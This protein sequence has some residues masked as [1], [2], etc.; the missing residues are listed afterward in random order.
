MNARVYSSWGGWCVATCLSAVWFAPGIAALADEKITYEDH[1]KPLL[2]QRCASCHNPNNKSGDLD[3]T[4]YTALML[5]GGS[6]PVI[7]PLEPSGSYM[8]KLITHEESPEMPPDADR[9]PDPEI[10]VIRKW[11]EGGG[12]ENKSSKLVA[13]KKKKVAAVSGDAT[14]RPEV[15]PQPC[16]LSLDVTAVPMR[17]PAVM[18]MATSPW[19]PITAVGT[20]FQVLLFDSQTLELRGVLPFP[21]G[22]IHALRFSRNGQLL[23]AGGGR[24][25]ANGVAVAWDI[26]TGERVVEISGLIDA[27]LAADISSDHTRVAVGTTDRL[28]RIFDTGSGEMLHEIKKHTD[29]IQSLEFSP[30]GVLLAT[31]DRSGGLIVWEALT[32]REYLDLRGHQA[33]INAVSWRVDSNVLASA[34]SDASIRL[35]EMENGG[36]IANWNGHGGGVTTVSFTRDSRILSGGRD[37]Q[38]KIFNQSGNQEK[39]YPW[40]SIV[41]VARFCDETNRL[42]ACDLNGQCKGRD[43]ANDAELGTL[44]LVI[45]KLEDRVAQ[46]TEQ[47]A[48]VEAQHQAL[49]SKHQQNT[50][51]HAQRVAQLETVQ[52]QYQTWTTQLAETTQKWEQ[53]KTQ[54]ASLQSQLQTA[55]DIVKKLGPGLENLTQAIDSVQRALATMQS[56]Q[57]E[58]SLQ[59]L[60][61]LK[62]A[63]EVQM[64]N[65]VALCEQ[66]PAMISAAESQ[67]QAEEQAKQTLVQQLAELEPMRSQLPKEIEA[68]AAAVAA[69]Q[70]EV[71]ASQPRL[72]QVVAEH[73]RL[74]QAAQFAAEEAALLTAI[75]QQ[76]AELESVADQ[77][78]DRMT[79]AQQTA[80]EIQQMQTEME[81]QQ[82]QIQAWQSE[83]AAAAQQEQTLKESITK[84]QA[85]IAATDEVAQRVVKL[86][87]ELEAAAAQVAQALA[88]HGEDAAVSELH[89]SLLTVVE[90]KRQALTQMTEENSQRNASIAGWQT[91][92][93]ESEKLRADRMG[94]VA[95]AE[96]VLASLA[97]SLQPKQT[98]QAAHDAAVAEMQATF[99]QLQDQVQS[100]RNQLLQLRGVNVPEADGLADL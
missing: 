93:Q 57:L 22:H 50:E 36:Q 99:D 54:V 73:Q 56:P 33:A 86:T 84:T 78:S 14:V 12:L 65:Q 43:V 21:E 58:T 18:A 19:A 7:E 71:Q 83:V 8:F 85:E 3:V 76:S 38:V 82:Q 41:T 59:Q 39:A 80:A 32:G 49:V 10:E 67:M 74:V 64:A 72:D 27:V 60:T 15:I 5:G 28:V 94:Q 4:N 29:W 16:R 63:N 17:E 26:Q 40:S 68:L 34:S 23:L 95:A 91:A 62:Q 81:N 20:P 79:T 24:A 96:Q 92:I 100:V 44:A 48:T 98:E 13:P 37:N 90:Q 89:R 1:V 70:T 97:Q 53:S 2:T 46:A 6:G 42:F 75:E 25:A 11:I 45:P 51:Q 66:L 77:L 61:E 87:Q 35:W 55:Q 47:R 88:A 30:D 52:Q 31:G 69:S 9:L